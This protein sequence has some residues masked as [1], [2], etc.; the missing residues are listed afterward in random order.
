MSSVITEDHKVQPPSA[1]R[2]DKS[3]KK[4]KHEKSEHKSKKRH[5]E[6]TDI[7]EGSER[8][9]KKTKSQVSH[10]YV[11]N[12][13]STIA[14]QSESLAPAPSTVDDNGGSRKEKKSKRTNK[15]K[16]SDQYTPLSINPEEEETKQDEPG[17]EKKKPKKDKR[18]H[19]ILE[20][21]RAMSDV[22]ATQPVISNSQDAPKPPETLAP[23]QKKGEKRKRKE[24]ATE[25]EAGHPGPMPSDSTPPQSTRVVSKVTGDHSNQTFPFFTQTV[26]Q[27]LPLYPT[28]MVEPID[29]YVEQQ[30]RPLLNRYVPAFRGVL[31]AYRNPRIGEAPGKSSLTEGSEVEDTA[32]LESID[33]YAVGF[34]WL[35]VDAELFC[36]KRGSWMEGTLNLQSEGS[37][38]VICF[39]MFNASIEASRLPSGWKWIDL[40]S[41]LNKG[42]GSKRHN[43]K[44]AAEAKLPTPEPQDENENENEKEGKSGEDGT[45]QAHSTGYW[46]DESGTRAGCGGKPLWFRIKNYEVGSIGDYGYLSIEGTMLDEETEKAKVADEME[47]DRRRKIKHGGLLG[48]PLKRLPEF[49]MTKFG[50]KD[51]EQE[52]VNILRSVTGLKSNRANSGTN[53]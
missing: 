15:D 2:K 48:R 28:G 42:K 46:V 13:V 7:A 18:K 44:T 49:S 16:R 29:G 37:I 24:R 9:H 38:G 11:N 32:L 43:G 23:K 5:R 4:S 51:D 53:S 45:D 25:T 10:Q 14:D 20:E 26:S 21:T 34:A 33:E 50:G 3:G 19:K 47:A 52:D 39:G 30:L 40:L 1:G 27:Y 41:D 22:D 17:K 12:T 36:P 35:T 6:T 8:K 31:L